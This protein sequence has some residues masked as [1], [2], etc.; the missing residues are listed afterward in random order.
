ME[1]ALAVFDRLK[2]LFAHKDIKPCSGLLLK[3]ISGPNK[4]KILSIDGSRMLFG[5][6]TKAQAKTVIESTLRLSTY[7]YC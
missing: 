3:F 7:K 1:R 5:S 2:Q 6:G 4:G